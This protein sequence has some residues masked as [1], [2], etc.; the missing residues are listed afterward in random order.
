M[1]KQ[2]GLISQ[3]V[4]PVLPTLVSEVTFPAQVNLQGEGLSPEVNFLGLEYKP[5][6]PILIA[7]FNEQYI[8][9]AN[10]AVEIDNLQDQLDQQAEQITDLQNAMAQVMTSFQQ[11]KSDV[12]NCCGMSD[13]TGQ[14]GTG[15]AVKDGVTLEQNIPNP[16]TGQTIISFDLPDAAAVRVEI[17]DSAGRLLETLVRERMDAGRHQVVWDGT[18]Y[19]SGVYYYSLYADTVLLTK[20]MIKR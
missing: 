9:V 15:P 17:S 11:T 5:F 3:E 19:P 4:Q 12:N 10:Q 2:Y 6:I 18:R 14:D 1:G 7:A 8:V 16:F 13:A 20:K